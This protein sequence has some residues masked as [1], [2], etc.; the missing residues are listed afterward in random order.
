MN[1]KAPNSNNTLRRRITLCGAAMTLALLSGCHVGPKYVA[2]VMPPPPEFKEAAPT[3]YAN[4]P[5]G[6]WKPAQPNDAAL[7]GKWWEAFNEPELNQLEDQ[8]NI[9]N[10]NIAQYFQN[11]MAARTL[12]RQAKSQYY[13][14]VTTDP[15][16][17]PRS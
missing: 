10:Q 7:K 4:A 17:H 11:F 5:D 1:L 12:V 2:P 14:T 8:V 16:L 6:T 15:L 3:A 13:P 9:N